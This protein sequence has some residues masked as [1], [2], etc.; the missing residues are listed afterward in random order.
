[1][2][3][4]AAI[5]T[6]PAVNGQA[7]LH[8]V[9]AREYWGRPLGQG[10][11][12]SYRPLVSL[13]FALERR[14][15]EAPWLPRVTNVLLF[16][17]LLLLLQRLATPIAGPR[18]AAAV[19][20]F[21]AALP[22]LAD[23]VASIVGRADVLATTLG[24]LALLAA[25]RGRAALAAL[26][27]LAA[28]LCKESVAL[29]PGLAIW[30]LWLQARRGERPWRD[31]W[32]AAV[33]LAGTGVLYIGLR[34][35]LLPVGL[36]PDFVGADNPFAAL[37]GPHRWWA[38]LGLLQRYA[39]ATVVPTALCNDHTYADVMPPQGAFGVDGWRSW[40]G[41]GLAG[42]LAWD[43]VR[44]LR[45]CSR[46]LWAAAALAY[47]VVGGWV[48]D[49]SVTFAERLLI[50]PLAV[51]ALAVAAALPAMRP[52]PVVLAAAGVLLLLYA[53]L[54]ARHGLEWSDRVELHR[55]SA[56]RCPAAVHN[57]LN[58]VQELL[59]RRQGDDVATA[60]WHLGVAAAGQQRFPER[61][62]VPAFAAE[63]DEPLAARLPRLPQL[64]LAPDPQRWWAGFLGMIARRGDAELLALAR[65]VAARGQGQ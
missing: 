61:F 35:S 24:L 5:L 14:V 23:N 40:L 64:L 30:L 34:Q 6:H 42:L 29:L 18:R 47:L 57:R 32:R 7:P 20:A 12:S 17:G 62:E 55:S 8:E 44:A 19:A 49:L 9:F 52:R 10:W 39:E 22:L 63:R 46:G 16:C 26:A 58:L 43:A 45:G 50:W 60:L 15:T 31:V 54:A 21:F 51:A 41:L 13:T 27:Y 3:D 65:A 38:N 4:D 28:L 11:S 59:R 53:A 36:P 56:E 2:D 48:V 33:A 37:H 1:M 25:Q